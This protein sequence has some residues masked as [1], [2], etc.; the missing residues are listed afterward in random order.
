MKLSGRAC[1]IV[2]SFFF[3][4]YQFCLQGGNIMAI[5]RFTDEEI[6]K[7]NNVSIMDYVNTLGLN[8]KKA[9]KTIKVEGHGGLCIDPVKNRWN[10]F[11]ASKGGGPIQLVMFLE[12]KTWVDAMKR[13]LGSNYESQD[14]RSFKMDIEKEKK[15]IK[16]DFILPKKNST[17]KHM[18]AYLTKTRGIDM[19]IIQ[20]FIDNKML[21]EDEKR[22]CVFVGY[23]EDKVPRYANLRGTNT[24]FNFK[25]ETKNSNKSYSFNLTNKNSDRV[26]V[27]ESPIEVMSYL[28]LYKL[29]FGKDKEF[30]YNA[31]S[32]GGTSDMALKQF[33]KDNKNIKEIHLCLN[34]DRAGISATEAIERKYKDNY[35]VKVKYPKLEDYN[36]LLCYINKEL[37]KALQKRMENLEDNTKDEEH[38]MEI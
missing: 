26:Y 11:S 30:K 13:L 9:G 34:N 37:E 7:A 16:K 23:D 22:N 31:L 32:L 19:G 24:F 2:G 35:K 5:K 25:G 4:L 33:L 6:T 14:I 20:N 21:Y 3:V 10:C 27:F 18:I 1:Y 28:T 8:T 29:K 12:N 36:D 17:Y 15:E 38:A